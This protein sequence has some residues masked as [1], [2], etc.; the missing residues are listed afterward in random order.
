MTVLSL[1][2]VASVV[3]GSTAQEALEDVTTVAI[4]AEAAG[5]H[6]IW[7]AEH[8]G[9]PGVASS[10]P[11]VLIAHLAAL[12][13]R[14]RVGSG[15]V[16]LPNHP[17][18]IVAEQF[19]TLEALHPGRIELGIG[20]A[21]GSD[22]RTMQAVG[23]HNPENFTQDL[24]ELVSYF[25]GTGPVLAMPGIGSLPELWLLGSSTYSA[26]VAG[27]MGI[28]YSFAYHFAPELLDQ[29]VAL[30]RESFRPSAVLEKPRVMVG[31]TVVC[32]QESEHAR[33]LAGPARMS[34]L[35]IRQG[36]PAQLMSPEKAEGFELREVDRVSLERVSANHIVGNPEEVAQGIGELVART[37]ADEIM[38][39]TRIHKV[40]DRI[41]SI[42]LTAKAWAAL[43]AS[44][45]SSSNGL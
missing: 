33:F 6:R 24:M 45:L 30:Y 35:F 39:S 8:H 5:L 12:T 19:G 31:A 20:R 36:R 21:P 3:E 40:E 2:E 18:Y 9:M 42:S 29:A 41:A 14:I 27:S 32:A 44:S 37:G 16:M 1:H 22:R 10:S 25:L 17:P 26:Q 28:P 38:L 15:G 43:K 13:T 4:A 23:R 7:L 34:S 11:S